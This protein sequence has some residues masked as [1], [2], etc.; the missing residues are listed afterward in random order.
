MKTKYE[1]EEVRIDQLWPGD[2]YLDPVYGSINRILDI[3]HFGGLI[4]L[5]IQWRPDTDHSNTYKHEDCSITDVWKKLDHLV[6]V[7]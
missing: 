1:C 7:L 4:K 5:E 3:R 6:K 2:V